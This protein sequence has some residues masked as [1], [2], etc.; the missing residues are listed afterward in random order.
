M[1]LSS[2]GYN[3]DRQ[4]IIATSSGN[5]LYVG[6]SGP[7]NYTRIQYAINDSS[8][9]DTVFVYDD[10]SPYYENVVVNKS[11]NLIGENKDTTVIDGE[12][13]KYVLE[14]RASNVLI[15]GFTV[16]NASGK[17]T[18]NYGQYEN[19]YFGAVVGFEAD[20]I[21]IRDNIIRNNPSEGLLFVKSGNNVISGNIIEDNGMRGILLFKDGQGTIITNNIVQK[22]K[23]GIQTAHGSAKLI[24]IQKNTIID[25]SNLGIVLEETYFSIISKNNFERNNQNAKI[26][27]YSNWDA[28][29]I[30]GFIAL[31]L[32]LTQ[33]MSIIIK[34]NYWDESR[35]LPYVINVD[36]R[37]YGHMSWMPTLEYKFFKLD[38]HPASEPYDIGV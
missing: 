33:S 3:L 19:V 36:I 15:T 38:K 7:N 37:I 32:V 6:G 28:T 25:N 23:V 12:G 4:S 17:S 22:N 24:S 29:P 31:I 8:D 13:K 20:Y 34:N 35:V 21:I 11:I 14:I 9:G 5:T 18:F 27:R 10:S 16:Q 26:N 2:T 30:E 1:S